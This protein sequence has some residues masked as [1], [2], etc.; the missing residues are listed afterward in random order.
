MLSILTP[1]RN[2]FC[3]FGSKDTVLLNEFPGFS[4]AVLS[5]GRP[6]GLSAVHF[7]LWAGRGAARSSLST[8]ELTRR[9]STLVS[10]PHLASERAKRNSPS[11]PSSPL[12]LGSLGR[13]RCCCCRRRT[14]A[15]R[16]LF[17]RVHCRRRRRR[18]RDERSLGTT[19]ISTSTTN[20]TTNNKGCRCG[21]R[22]KYKSSTLA[23]WSAD[24]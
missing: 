10:A 22:R 4:D 23:I 1:R 6:A 14:T 21:R 18:R 7:P 9:V 8:N 5:P 15:I 3:W 2:C 12:A 11:S 16:P 17:S 13:R 24:C 19:A 20:G